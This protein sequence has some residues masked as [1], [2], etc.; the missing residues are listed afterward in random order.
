[1]NFCVCVRR[2]A[3]RSRTSDP[4]TSLIRDATD[5]SPNRPYWGYSGRAVIEPHMRALCQAGQHSH[6]AMHASPAQ[7]RRAKLQRSATRTCHTTR[8][9]QAA[10]GPNVAE[11]F[12]RCGEY[13]AKIL[14]GAKPSRSMG[15]LEWSIRDQDTLRDN[16]NS[17]SSALASFRS[18]VS[19]PSVN[20]P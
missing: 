8:S 15:A 17:S 5:N 9:A 10:Y 12:R 1:M 14:H 2:E 3:E 19:N 20:Q 16:A 4:G 13:V 7:S 6:E 18:S 11:I